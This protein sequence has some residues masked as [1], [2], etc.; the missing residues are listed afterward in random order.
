[1]LDGNV[2]WAKTQGLQ[3]GTSLTKK[4]GRVMPGEASKY[5]HRGLIPLQPVE[6]NK[7]Q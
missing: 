2:D 1:M 5:Q 4:P 3:A 6:K 7:I